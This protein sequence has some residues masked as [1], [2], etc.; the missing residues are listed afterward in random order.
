MQPRCWAAFNSPNL[1]WI[2]IIFPQAKSQRKESPGQTSLSACFSSSVLPGELSG[3]TKLVDPVW[4]PGKLSSKSLGQQ[5]KMPDPWETISTGFQCRSYPNRVGPGTPG[6]PA[7]FTRLPL[8]VVSKLSTCGAA[9]AHVCF[10]PSGLCLQQC[11]V[12]AQL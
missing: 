8:K 2:L 9:E 6:R 3:Q 7:A 4:K 1:D 12:T 5:S 10:P 11:R